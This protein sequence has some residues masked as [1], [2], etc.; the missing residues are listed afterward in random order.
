MQENVQLVVFPQIKKCNVSKAFNIEANSLRK[1]LIPMSMVITSII[2][3]ST[4]SHFYNC[5][6]KALCVSY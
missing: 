1:D 6:H 2:N 3:I 5:F 4:T